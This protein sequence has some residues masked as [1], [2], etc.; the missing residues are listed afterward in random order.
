MW[1]PRL[2]ANQEQVQRSGCGKSEAS[3]GGPLLNTIANIVLVDVSK[4]ASGGLDSQVSAED[5]RRRGSVLV[6]RVVSPIIWRL[7]FPNVSRLFAK[8]E[9]RRRRR[10]SGSGSGRLRSGGGGR[11]GGNGG[12]VGVDSLQTLEQD[13]GEQQQDLTAQQNIAYGDHPHASPCCDSGYRKWRR[14]PYTARRNEPALYL[15]LIGQ[16]YLV[17]AS[18]G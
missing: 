3:R 14:Y 12:I 6:Q 16:Q 18:V 5:D 15:L 8:R 17:F 4:Q 9:H 2:V 10:L 7:G 13:D 11:G 1:E